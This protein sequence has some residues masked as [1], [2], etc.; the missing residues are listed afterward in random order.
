MK[1][2]NLTAKLSTGD[3]ILI[4]AK[5]HSK[6]LVSLYNRASQLKVQP[7][8]HTMSSP[9]DLDELAFAEFI[10]YIDESLEVEELAVLKAF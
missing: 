1:D 3:L 4:D 7:A 9:I 10:A 6:C 5:Y 8:N 2:S